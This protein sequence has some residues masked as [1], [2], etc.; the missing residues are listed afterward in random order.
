LL[1][2]E[3]EGLDL[4]NVLLVGDRVEAMILGER[5]QDAAVVHAWIVRP[6]YRGGGGSAVL[7]G[8]WLERARGAG[9]RSLRFETA[10]T[11]RDPMK[12]VDRV[13]G[14]VVRSRATYVRPVSL[15]SA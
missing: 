1:S 15:E 10:D 3:F 14:Q 11:T 12:V 9:L 8:L 2:R 6:G 4:S 13:R 7:V 5:R